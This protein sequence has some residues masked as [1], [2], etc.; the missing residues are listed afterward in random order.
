MDRGESIEKLA[1]ESVRIADETGVP[2]V[3]VLEDRGVVGMR[4]SMWNIDEMDG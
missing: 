4:L 2:L 1:G 3:V